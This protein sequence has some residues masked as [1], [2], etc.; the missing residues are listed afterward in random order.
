MHRRLERNHLDFETQLL[1]Q[2]LRPTRSVFLELNEFRDSIFIVNL[3]ADVLVTKRV[4]LETNQSSSIVTAQLALELLASFL[5]KLSED[6]LASL[7]GLLPR[8]VLLER[9]L[10]VNQLDVDDLVLT[11]VSQN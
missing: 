9:L 5:Y 1:P 4:T 7:L 6:S 10:L 2:P 11:L 3:D 8:C